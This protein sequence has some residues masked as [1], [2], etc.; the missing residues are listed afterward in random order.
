MV[1]ASRQSMEV[2]GSSDLSDADLMASL[3][4]GSNEAL[5]TLYDRHAD[6]VFTAARRTTLDRTLAGDVVQ[7]TFLALWNRAESF[8]VA[9]GSLRAWLLTIARNRAIDQL[10]SARRHAPALPFAAY[11]DVETDEASIAEWLTTSGSTIAMASP[12]PEPEEVVDA[13]EQRETIVDALVSLAPVERSVILLAYA[14][15]LSQSEI[16]NRLGWPIGT[17]KTRTR[18][19]LHHLRDR[20]GDLP[21][22]V[23]SEAIRN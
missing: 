18:R 1:D 6:A 8:D 21:G 17:V 11:G 3:I 4:G 9:R 10:R 16:A 14:E 5:A 13:R 22:D 7:E 20:L 12:A 19:A 2:T 23:G 15:E